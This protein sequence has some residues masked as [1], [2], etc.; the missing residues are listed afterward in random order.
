MK[1]KNVKKGLLPYVVLLVVVL[2]VTYV[3]TFG[4]NKVNDITYDKLLSELR[5]GNVTELV[6]TP[7]SNEGTYVITGKLE[8]YG[9]KESFSTTA[10]L[11]DSI[12]SQIMTVSET[13]EYKLDTDSDPSSSTLLFLI[14]NFLPIIIGVGLIYWFVTRQI[15]VAGK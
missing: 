2:F 12:V 4:G 13:V 5:E 8:G 1:K 9:E 15:S 11:T 14:I 7:H 3:I 6:I 10:P